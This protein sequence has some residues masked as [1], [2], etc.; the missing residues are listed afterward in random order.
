LS[1]AANTIPGSN[2]DGAHRSAAELAAAVPIQ[3]L[4]TNSSPRKLARS[5][6]SIF[7]P[8]VCILRQKEKGRS[9]LRPLT[10]FVDLLDL[11]RLAILNPRGLR[12]RIATITYLQS[13]LTTVLP[14]I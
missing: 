10:E 5:P 11:K 12:A 14:D 9:H 4:P 2:K 8:H 1:V 3:D 13:N 6:V 7:P